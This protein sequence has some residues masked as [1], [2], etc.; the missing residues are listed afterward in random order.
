MDMCPIT[1]VGV[2]KG[3][4]LG[5]EPTL[6]VPVEALQLL[7]QNAMDDAIVSGC[8]RIADAGKH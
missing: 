7:A 4:E 3:R 6:P 8:F 5:E 2:Q 1:S